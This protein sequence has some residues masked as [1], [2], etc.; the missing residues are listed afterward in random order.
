MAYFEQCIYCFSIAERMATMASI[1]A[2]ACFSST[3][4]G[5]TAAACCF[6]KVFR[7]GDIIIIAVAAAFRFQQS[8]SEDEFSNNRRP[9]MVLRPAADDVDVDALRGGGRL[10]GYDA[11]TMP[12]FRRRPY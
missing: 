1:E 2:P 5:A 10:F 9:S 3:S 11:S 12:A 4:T 8:A 7:R 6:D